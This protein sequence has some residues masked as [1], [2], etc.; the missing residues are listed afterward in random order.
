M[1]ITASLLAPLAKLLLAPP[2]ELRAAEPPIFWGDSTRLGRPFAK[3]PC[4]IRFGGHYLL[5]CTMAEWA[6]ELAPPNSPRLSPAM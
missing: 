4:V 6:K 3:D 5:Y 2:G 1:S